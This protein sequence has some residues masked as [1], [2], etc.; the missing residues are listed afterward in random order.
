MTK[1]VGGESSFL[2]FQLE[3]PDPERI[4]YQAVLFHDPSGINR[5]VVHRQCM[6]AKTGKDET[7]ESHAVALK[8]LTGLLAAA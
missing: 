7:T 2:A 1:P 3:L 8:I 5:L 4:R 6:S